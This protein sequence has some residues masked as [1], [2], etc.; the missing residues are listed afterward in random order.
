MSSARMRLDNNVHTPAAANSSFNFHVEAR[1]GTS[2]MCYILSA[3]GDEDGDELD[4]CDRQDLLI[5]DE[6]I[7]IDTKPACIFF[8]NSAD[9]APHES[10]TDL[11]S[12]RAAR[13]KTRRPS[14]ISIYE[15][16]LAGQGLT[17]VLYY[18]P[19]V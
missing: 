4:N 10:I 11:L 3:P 13:F 18:Q 14:P 5:G 15:P 2:A 6:I 8:E 19:G 9:K 1:T 7:E 12:Q 16:P 17:T